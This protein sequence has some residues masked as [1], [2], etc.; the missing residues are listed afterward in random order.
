[1]VLIG[2]YAPQ[3]PEGVPCASNGACP[4]PLLCTRGHCERDLV[5]DEDAFVCTP[6]A[7]GTGLL[8]APPIAAP[9]LDGDLADW[10]TCFVAIDPTTNPVRDLDGTKR[11]LSGRF[12]I[13]HDAT[14]IYVAVE[15]MGIAPLGDQPLPAVY[16]NNSISLYVDGDGS[17]TSMLYDADAF[18]IVVDHAN[19]VQAFRDGGVRTATGLTS[20]VKTTGTMFSIEVAI[21]PATFGRTSFASSIGFDLGLEGGDGTDQYSETWWYR[22]CGPPACGCANGMAAPYCDARGFG[23]AQI[24]P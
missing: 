10:T 5:P 4:E 13:A 18:Q 1:M 3:P 23:R 9:A 19:R 12:S 7:A 11:Y 2:C 17:F 16:K 15:V 20:A 8:T 22:A 6:I 14:H 24:A 21:P